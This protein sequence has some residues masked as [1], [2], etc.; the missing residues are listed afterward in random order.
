[1]ISVPAAGDHRVPH[2]ARPSHQLPHLRVT[3][4][5]SPEPTASFAPISLAVFVP[6]RALALAG[7]RGMA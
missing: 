3:L 1:V 7:A 5:G 4:I 6:E 2:R